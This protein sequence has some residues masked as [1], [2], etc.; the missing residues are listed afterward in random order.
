MNNEKHQELTLKELKQAIK[1]CKY[2]S[3]CPSV[4][5]VEHSGVPVIAQHEYMDGSRLTAYENGYVTYINGRRKTVVAL[6]QCGNY[7]YFTRTGE[8]Y[9]PES[10]FMEMP[11]YVRVQMEA[12]DRI[13]HNTTAYEKDKNIRFHQSDLDENSASDEICM[14]QMLETEQQ[15]EQLL[16]LL[17][18]R[19]ALIMRLCY[20]EELERKTVAEILGISISAVTDAISKSIKRL[21][22]KLL[23]SDDNSL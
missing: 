18:E 15:V 14:E 6:K 12:D 21:R 17:T 2:E 4:N 22:K 3:R 1:I 20:L 13:V 7:T 16:A 8:K 10:S 9:I 5:A 19:Q 11:W 23:E